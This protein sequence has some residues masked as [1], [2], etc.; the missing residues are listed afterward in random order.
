M[1]KE[2]RYPLLFDKEGKK[3]TIEEYGRLAE[4]MTYK[5]V[6]ETTLPDK[7]WISTVWLGV[8][9]GINSKN[10]ILFET[11]VFP[12]RMKMKERDCERYSTLEEAKKGHERMVERWTKKL[13]S[14][15][16][17]KNDKSRA[18]RHK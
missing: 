7:T 16:R 9:H 15:K 18:N 13:E 3:I 8:N 11:M 1:S 14:A 2:F 5:R 4:D 12:S 17:R 6:A 10:L